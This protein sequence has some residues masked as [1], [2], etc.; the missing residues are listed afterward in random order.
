ME[1][2]ISNNNNQNDILVKKEEPCALC[3]EIEGEYLFYHSQH[4]KWYHK[5]CFEEYTCQIKNSKR[6]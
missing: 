6:A 3:H 1:N 2:T 5:H 4:E